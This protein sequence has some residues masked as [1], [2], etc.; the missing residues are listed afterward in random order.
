MPN[1]ALLIGNGVNLLSGEA[2][3]WQKLLADLAAS[4]GR[5]ELMN[6]WK[7]KPFSLLFE[8]IALSNTYCSVAGEQNVKRRVAEIVGTIKGNEY[9]KR[10]L[11]LPV[12]HIL[13]TNYDYCLESAHDQKQKRSNLRRETK[14]NVFR[15][16]TVGRT[17]IWHIHGEIDAPNTITLGH[18]QYSG[19]LQKLRN[20]ATA[21]RSS[22]TRVKSPF[23][24]NRVNFEETD[25]IYSWVDVFFRD[26]IH[27]LGFSLDYTEIDLWWLL[28]YKEKLRRSKG[29]QVGATYFYEFSSRPID[30]PTK[31]KHSIL[32]SLGT[33]VIRE[34]IRG[35]EYTT[36]Y[37]RF[38]ENFPQ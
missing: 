28:A 17:R 26:D 10:L 15:S 22:K 27:I 20:Y 37:V 30:G 4:A 23:K 36:A 5:P 31:A 3:S 13:T 16:R 11:G 1:N 33:S 29:Y 9:H 7:F 38:I 14:Y 6:H 2:A 35:N 8:E 34:E 21:D 12:K 18:E 24:L 19:Q 32:K 25:K